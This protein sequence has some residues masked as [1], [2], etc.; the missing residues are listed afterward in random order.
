MS[1]LGRVK[2]LGSGLWLRQ[3]LRQQQQQTRVLAEIAS[4]LK[5]LTRAVERIVPPP[6][7]TTALPSSTDW[8]DTARD[9]DYLREVYDLQADLKTRWNRPVDLEEAAEE[10]ESRQAS[11]KE[12]QPS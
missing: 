7:D 3:V 6:P 8:I 4:S 2:A 9:D 11:L 10:Y 5:A 12:P 1:L